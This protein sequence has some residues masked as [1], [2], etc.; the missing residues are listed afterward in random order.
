MG[1]SQG[2]TLFGSIQGW[3]IEKLAADAEPPSAPMPAAQAVHSPTNLSE[4][5]DDL[6][7]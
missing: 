4:E 7:F 5:P 1:W 3:R 2:E 6:P